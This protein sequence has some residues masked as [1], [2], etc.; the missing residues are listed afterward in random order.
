MK[1]IHVRKKVGH[2]E[3]IE[4]FDIDKGTTSNKQW[5][6]YFIWKW[7]QLNKCVLVLVSFVIV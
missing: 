1:L 4:G 3:S 2:M 7:C 5:I 6:R